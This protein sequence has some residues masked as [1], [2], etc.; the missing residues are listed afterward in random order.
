MTSH[1]TLGE[2]RVTGRGAHRW[3][4]GHPWIYRSD[5]AEGPARP[6]LVRVVDP[7]GRFLGQALWSPA[8]EIRLRLLERTDIGPRKRPSKLTGVYSGFWYWVGTS[9]KIDAGVRYSV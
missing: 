1:A 6:G 7:Q 4:Q 5:A 3:V 9:H 2:V 8:S